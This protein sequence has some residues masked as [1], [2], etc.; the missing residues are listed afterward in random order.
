[1]T[2]Y[3]NAILALICVIVGAWISPPLWGVASL[4]AILSGDGLII[5]TL[6]LER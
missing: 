4:A 2:P 6:H 1:M 5:H 3:I